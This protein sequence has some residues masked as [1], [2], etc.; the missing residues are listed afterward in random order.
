[1][2]SFIFLKKVLS[3]EYFFVRMQKT[4]HMYI[5][6]KQDYLSNTKKLA[7][8]EIQGGDRKLFT[9]KEEVNGRS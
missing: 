1:M 2:F 6:S 3:T 4:R 8:S 9:S 7:L 5:G